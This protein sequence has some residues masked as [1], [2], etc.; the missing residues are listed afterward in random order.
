V[1][2][3]SSW[4]RDSTFAPAVSTVDSVFKTSERY[5]FVANRGANSIQALDPYNG[6]LISEYA[7]PGTSSFPSMG[8]YVDVATHRIFWS[9]R[10]IGYGCVMYNPEEVT[11]PAGPLWVL[12]E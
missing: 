4:V 8:L 3:G 2:S 1:K 11:T 7:L 9:R 6:Y 12:Y 5:L 10:G